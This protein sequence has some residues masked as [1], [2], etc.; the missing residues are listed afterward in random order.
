MLMFTSIRPQCYVG[1]SGDDASQPSPIC[2]TLKPKC[3]SAK[4][5]RNVFYND[6][7]FPNKLDE[8]DHLLHNID[9][10]I[11]LRKKTFPTPPNDVDNPDFNHVYSEELRGNKLQSDL[12]LSHL[13]PKDAAAL[14]AIIKEYWCVFDNHGSFTLIRNYQCIIDTG[15]ATLITIKKI[16]YG[17]R[18]ILIMQKSIAAL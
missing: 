13:L 6:W 9:G 14:I 18:E 1:V 11:I 4:K 5:A 10:G 15:T 7:G 16:L 8:Y 3:Q 12:D 17:R 2:I